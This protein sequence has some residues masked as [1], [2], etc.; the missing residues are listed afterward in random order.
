VAGFLR[1]DWLAQAGLLL[2]AVPVTAQL[3]VGEL[4]THLSGTIAP[5]YTAD[6]SNM[7]GSDHSWALGGTATYSGFFYNP[8][9]L[10]FNVGLYL[11]Q[12]RA[13]SDFQSIS[14][15]SG[16][17]ATA[18]IFGGSHFP[19]TVNYSK[20]WNSEGNYAVPGIANYVTHGNNDALGVNWSE[21]LPDAPSV[22]VGYQIGD[23]QYTVYGAN[24]EGES[25]FRSLNVHSS[26]QLAGFNMAGYYSTGDGHSLIPEIVT[27][28]A[29]TEIES[30]NGA[31]GFNVSHMLPLHG[32]VSGAFSRSD[33]DTDYPGGNSTG[34]IDIIN[35]LASAHP[36]EKLSFSA[37][38]S[39]SDNL[40]GQLIQSVV[41]A[42]G[43]PPVLSSSEPSNSLDLQGIANYKPVSNLQ[44]SAYVERRTQN[45]E[46]DRYG[47][48]SYGG[49]ASYA[50]EYAAGYFSASLDATENTSDQTGE[51]TLGF[52]STENYSG[53]IRGW[54]VSGSFS[55]AQN[56]QT[57]LVTYMNSYYNYSGNIRRRWINFN[58]TAGAG[59]SHTALTQQAGTAN[60]S[61]SFNASMGYTPW[62]AVTAGYAKASGQALATGAGLVPV[63]IPVPVLP[64]S[65]VSLFGGSSYSIGLSSTP[66]KNL[67]LTAAYAKSSSNTSSSSLTSTNQNNQFNAIIQYHVRKLSFTSGFARLEQGFSG[68]STGP[69]VVSSF[70]VGV[71]R[72]FNFF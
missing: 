70:Y 20:A 35:T 42:G 10:S 15:A 4:S 65:L 54:H 60:S 71:S 31:Y 57:L 47:V 43:V 36:T 19:G 53:E 7:T 16:V 29:P 38:A 12:S 3:K 48:T 45:F 63:P 68:S 39:Y 23:S 40:T 24:D 50:R 30:N 8:N 32:S 67:V 2:L 27:G 9:F 49:S 46:G 72:W 52:S 26:Y 33:W 69:E 55:Y 41:G 61:Q 11:N 51:D 64:S 13:N 28:Q 59:A 18:N 22:S 6:Y 62:I 37:S 5:G 66:I 44:T 58:V 25:S 34:T 21:N 17:N 56:V 1:V 14:N